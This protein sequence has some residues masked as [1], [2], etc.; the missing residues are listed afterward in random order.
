MKMRNKRVCYL[1]RVMIESGI[2]KEQILVILQKVLE[3]ENEDLELLVN[4]GEITATK[5]LTTASRL[6]ALVN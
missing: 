5:E 3:V 1:T 2:N 6:L 4:A